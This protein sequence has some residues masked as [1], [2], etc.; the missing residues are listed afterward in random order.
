MILIFV[1]YFMNVYWNDK[2]VERGIR[3][4]HVLFF[5]RCELRKYFAT[6]KRRGIKKNMLDSTPCHKRL[7]IIKRLN[8][9]QI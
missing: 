4:M 9:K 6:K 5:A 1:I 3:G 8:N 7:R 2:S